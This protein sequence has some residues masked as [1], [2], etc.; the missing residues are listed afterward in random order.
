MHSAS[1][2]LDVPQ[3]DSGI[4]ATR[5]GGLYPGA[6][7]A[8]K[9]RLERLIGSG[10]MGAVWAAHNVALGV[11][12]ALKFLVPAADREATACRLHNEARL[13]ASIKHPSLVAVH[14]VGVC[15][16]GA[17]D[18][19]FIVME[20]LEGSDLDTL[21]LERG[22]LP[23]VEVVR[24]MLPILD[25]LRA[26]H[27]QGVIHRDIKP[28]NI[29]LAKVQGRIIPKL[30]DFGAALAAKS[31]VDARLTHAG[32]VIGS[33]LYMSPEQARGSLDLDERVDVW[34]VSAALYEC[35][36]G[37][38]PFEAQSYEALLH[39][40]ITG[41]PSPLG[42][43]GAA[44]KLEAIVLEGLANDPNQRW[45]SVA[46]LGRALARWLLEQGVHDDIVNQ[47]VRSVWLDGAAISKPKAKSRQSSRRRMAK[48]AKWVWPALSGMLLA[49]GGLLSWL[50]AGDLPAVRDTAASVETVEAEPA[51]T[52]ISTDRLAA[53]ADGADEGIVDDLPQ[54]EMLSVPAQVV[55]PEVR[56]TEQRAVRSEPRG[57]AKRPPQATKPQSSFD[58]FWGF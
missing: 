23:A 17:D 52:N 7:I 5:T 26:A 19:D 32:T 24:L 14:D 22:A 43:S 29:F 37:C 16:Q 50:A 2:R 12:V 11:A 44:A 51:S 33:P 42:L 20:L 40:I 45:P 28:G 39:T 53:I 56:P 57:E 48:G 3:N 15:D 30:V 13:L 21:L 35:L 8:G 1:L 18:A 31:Q 38:P 6:L 4:A 58:P 25:G 10:G 54:A 34:G 47:S 46:S 41:H 49:G 55:E 36:S 9:Y 27:A